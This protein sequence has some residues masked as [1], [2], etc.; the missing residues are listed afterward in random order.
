MPTELWFPTP[1]YYKDN[2]LCERDRKKLIDR[3]YEIKKSI[4]S[5]HEKWKCKLYTSF[6][7]HNA[8][9][10]PEF[11][12]LLEEIK[13]NVNNFAKELGSN[14][15]YD[16]SEGWINIYDA[17][18]Y[19]EYHYHDSSI[20]SVI[21]YL[22]APEGSGGTIFRSP[23]EPDML[24]LKNVT[25]NNNLNYKVCRY[26]A[27]TN[28]LVIFRSYLEHMVEQGTNTEDRISLSFNF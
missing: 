10:D 24:P 17:T 11:K 19:Q 16:S 20:F 1:I 6:Q 13:N 12:T 28:R 25:E 15:E 26:P 8:I 5:N 3:C 18:Q 7:N 27:T 22:S 14:Y 2:I 23:L 9:N 4:P 21:Y